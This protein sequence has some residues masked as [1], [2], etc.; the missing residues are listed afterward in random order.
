[1]TTVKNSNHLRE[2][3]FVSFGLM[4]LTAAA[5]WWHWTWH[6]DQAVYDAAQSTWLRSPAQDIVI[7]AVDDASLQAIGRWPWKRAIHAQALK[8]IQ[9]AGPKSVMLDLLLSEADTDP[10]QDFVL[11]QAM[12]ESG[13][14]VLPV[15]HALDG[16]GQGH[17]LRP[18]PIF[19]DNAA[20]AHA[21]AAMDVDGTV[22][23]AYLWAGSQANR[24]PHPALAMLKMA[25]EWPADI[26][27]QSFQ[28]TA[29][30]S[31]YW[32]REQA[33]PIPFLGAPGRI[34]HVS[35]AAVLRGEVAP[36]TFR[37][38]H[39][40][41]GVTAHGLGE[42][43]QTPVSQQGEGMSGVEVIAQFLDALRQGKRIEVLPKIAHAGLSALLVLALLWHFRQ[44]TPRHALIASAILAMGAVLASWALM[45]WGIWWPPF[46][47]T[48][49]ALLSYP[50]WSWR[51]LEAT[52]QDLEAELRAMAGEPDVKAALPARERPVGA[53]FMQQ[54]T[55]A[56]SRAGA[57][58]RQA[59]QLLAHTLAT[60]PDA[61]FV[62]DT[63]HVVT[64]A[65]QQACA[66]TGFS[67]P[68]AL[69]GRRLGEILAPLTPTEA[70]TWDMLLDKAQ[71][72]HKAMS[73]EAVHPRGKQYLMAMVAVDHEAPDSGV[74]V[75]ATD[76]TALQ[77]AELQRAELLGFIAHDIRSPQAS[78][79]SLVELHRIGGHMS[80]EETLKH[81]ESMARHTLELCE[82]LLQVMRAETRAIAP[83]PGDLVKLAEGC[84]SDMQLQARAKD[85][86]L[87][88]DWPAGRTQSASFDDYLVHR[89]LV[90][91]LSNAIKFSPKGGQVSVSVKQ[92]RHCHVIA[93]RDQGPGIPESE[94][95]RLFKRYERVEQG[96]P[97]KLAAG[98]GLGLV[99]IDTVA[100]RH[101]GEV[102]VIN[103]PGE[104]ACFELWLPDSLGQH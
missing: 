28:E 33:M 5:C 72:A 39:V 17:E 9:Q 45:A 16:V 69:I 25:G 36:G 21:D 78:L 29:S 68:S 88:G 35:Y 95:G 37:N 38:R 76:V 14:V 52:A 71:Q 32:H 7:V 42:T 55:D 27:P 12:R 51:K 91:L 70:P 97:S 65:N 83:M 100:R 41:I 20:L 93:V 90:N 24:Y 34:A 4:A 11:A 43:F 102:K 19:Q 3:W 6:L 82:E 104:G 73:T 54:R 101:G 92:E 103:S 1:M 67:Q 49:G 86:T 94:L 60:L 58:L 96:R 15:S 85:I 61:V 84:M 46:G 59:R 81:V 64:Q 75:C 62:V 57:Q 22:R 98:I 40:L 10:Q 13:K 89:A 63:H 31:P 87:S 48:L 77:E 23:W 74:I 66:M 30:T 99:F 80:Q 18:L 56:I 53:D 8:Q 79:I 44:A 50:V 26:P 47:L 2:W